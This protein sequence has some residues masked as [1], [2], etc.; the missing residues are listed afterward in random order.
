MTDVALKRDPGFVLSKLKETAT[1]SVITTVDA[2]IQ[3]PE[4]FSKKKMLFVG[5]E[6]FAVGIF[7][8]IIGDKYAVMNVNSMININPATTNIVTVNGSN[9]YEFGFPAGSV[10][11]KNTTVVKDDFLIYNIFDE[12]LS[13]GNV[14]WYMTYEDMAKI[15]STAR[16]YAAS[17]IGDNTTVIHLLV[18]ILARNREDRMKYYRH[19]LRTYKDLDISPSFVPLKS[20]MYIASNTLNKFAGSYFSEAIVSALVYPADKVEKIETLLRE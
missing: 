16:E 19:Q 1:G 9:Y 8:I 17:K 3:I 6:T 7:A 5:E 18:S 11:I 20:V 10:L 13:N 12:L 2:K 14:P 15:Y 4:R